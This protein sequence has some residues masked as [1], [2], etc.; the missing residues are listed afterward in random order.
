[1]DSLK[2]YKSG[3]ISLGGFAIG[4]G[5]YFAVKYLFP[6]QDVSSLELMFITAF[7]GWLTNF[8]KMALK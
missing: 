8:I 7:G 2:L 1:M 4:V 3:L 5:A 6:S